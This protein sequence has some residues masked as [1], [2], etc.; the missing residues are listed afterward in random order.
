MKS[1]IKPLVNGIAMV[2]SSGLSAP[3]I[4]QDDGAKLTIE[5]VVVTARR[6]EELLQDV[7]VAITAMSAEDIQ[8]ENIGTMQDF[9]GKVPSLTI[10]SNSQMRNTET[11]T[12]R[13][14]GA[15][16]SAGPGV[17]LY[18]G[19][20]PLPSDVSTNAQ[21]GPGKFFDISNVQ[22]L[23]GAQGTLFGRNSTG[24]AVL[25]E[26]TKPKNEFFASLKAEATSYSGRGYEG[27][28]NTPLID[29]VLLLRAGG[30]FFDREGFTKDVV[31]GRDYDNK[32]FWTTRLSLTWL[33]TD[34]IE[35]TLFG[36]YTESDD[37]GTGTVL[38]EIKQSG[39][40]SRCVPINLDFTFQSDC[41]QSIVNDQTARGV[42]KVQLSADP[43][44]FVRTYAGIDKF[45]FDINDQLTLKNIASYTWF[46][47][48][49]R[50]DQDGSLLPLSDQTT[51][52]NVRATNQ[53]VITEELQLQGVAF[54][55]N[56][57]YVAGAY[58]EFTDADGIA[59]NHSGI[60]SFARR[61]YEI[62]KE[63]YAPF[64]QG[65]YDF[66]GLSEALSGLK[67]TLGA[68]Y[69][70]DIFRGSGRVA[71]WVPDGFNAQPE[72][73]ISN[74]LVDDKVKESAGTFTAGLDYKF[75]DHLVYGKISRGYKPGGLQVTAVNRNNIR[76]DPEYVV[77]YEL[78]LK[79]D[80]VIA[81]M[82]ARLNTA[83]YYTDYTDMQK[84]GADSGSNGE[85]GAATYNVGKAAIQGAELEGSIQPVP[86]L[87]VS[88]NYSYTDAEYKEFDLN[89]NY[90][91]LIDCSGAF[92]QPNQNLKADLSCLPVQGV[93]EHQGSVNVRYMLP[94]NASL[95]EV[96]ASV[97]YSSS[98]RQYS[99]QISVPEEEPGSWLPSY[100]LL[101]ASLS[102]RNILE[103]AF[104]AQL[105]GTNLTDEE[106]RISN[107]NVWGVLGYRSSIY[108]EP[109]IIG[110]K[111]GYSWK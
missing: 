96:E 67:L 56:F 62:K 35:N 82:P 63:S 21:G 72:S 107:S 58:Y 24:G 16:Y 76:F 103:T 6:K 73:E 45:S 42:R 39:T 49:Y 85:P 36:Y 108:S 9:Q 38:E 84:T 22:V 52:D 47:H 40:N 86:G 18:W 59:T 30:Q 95:G 110:L 74:G 41:G 78:G 53:R 93:A 101:G 7:P 65:T 79:S 44:V 105:Y 29:D 15:T 71:V 89:V 75:G 111:V 13:G 25:I 54:N 106:Y 92:I 55:D 77:N 5:E 48:L 28:F 1:R 50:W 4:A 26:P 64:A 20:V 99:A 69:T 100:G 51:P 66:G 88:A 10:G 27:I 70:T 14:Q 11:P 43:R 46:E 81:G 109:R 17:I 61:Q 91:G 83:I 57:N 34:S 80:Y 3:L 102:W 23:K 104:E 31:T 94:L 87:T 12:I 97:T 37:N 19:E 90:T 60:V 33:P 32:H 68:R 98:S 2:L 8:R